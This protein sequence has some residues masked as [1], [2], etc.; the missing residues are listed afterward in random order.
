[1]V[2]VLFFH[3]VRLMPAPMPAN[4]SVHLLKIAEV[5]NERLQNSQYP[6]LKRILCECHQ[7]V[8][9]L[10]GRL[11][12]FFYKQLAQEAVARVGGVSQVVNEIEVR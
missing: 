2:F 4:S 12:S 5:A 1:M 7:D 11:P 8:L 6:A 3:G 10:K 9:V